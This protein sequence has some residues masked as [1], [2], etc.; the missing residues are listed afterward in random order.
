MYFLEREEILMCEYLQNFLHFKQK[1]FQF[2]E[3]VTSEVR[4]FYNTAGKIPLDPFP[5]KFFLLELIFQTMDVSNIVIL[6]GYVLQISQSI[7]YLYNITES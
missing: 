5:T 4:I 7:C 2:Y 6:C 3:A 1:K